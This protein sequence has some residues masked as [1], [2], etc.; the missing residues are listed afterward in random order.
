MVAHGGISVLD[1]TQ[2]V[3]G[4]NP[5]Q[6]LV[7]EV[8]KTGNLQRLPSNQA[9]ILSQ[10]LGFL[11]VVVNSLANTSILF[12]LVG[13]F[14]AEVVIWN[15]CSES[16]RCR[17]T[18]LFYAGIETLSSTVNLRTDTRWKQLSEMYVSVHFFF[19]GWKRWQHGRC[20]EFQY[21]GGCCQVVNRFVRNMWCSYLTTELRICSL[22][23]SASGSVAFAFYLAKGY[24]N[25]MSVKWFWDENQDYNC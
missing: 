23:W 4:Q 7:W 13:Y 24:L 11:H 12:G 16:L 10:R 15:W 3:T 5:V 25:L 2:Q 6:A 20:Q 18:A 19:S 22:V 14:C 9:V 21:S 17:W 8:I 1:D